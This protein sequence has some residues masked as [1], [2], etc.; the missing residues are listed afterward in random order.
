VKKRFVA[1]VV[2]PKFTKQLSSRWFSTFFKSE[3]SL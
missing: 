1:F 2:R 3:P